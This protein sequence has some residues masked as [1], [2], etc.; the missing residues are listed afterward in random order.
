MSNCYIYLIK[1]II[2]KSAK[3]ANKIMVANSATI[4]I[5]FQTG[6]YFF[7]NFKNVYFF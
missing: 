7:K 4:Y 3:K 1:F 5:S 2:N 6:I